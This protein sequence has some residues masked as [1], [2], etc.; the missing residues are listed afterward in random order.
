MDNSAP[1]RKFWDTELSSQASGWGV[2]CSSNILVEVEIFTTAKGVVKS[3]VAP[4]KSVESKV[5][6]HGA[7]KSCGAT[8]N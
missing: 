8:G 6:E 3:A 2:I 1:L 4:V 7:M 5:K